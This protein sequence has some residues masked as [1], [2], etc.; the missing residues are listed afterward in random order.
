MRGAT[1]EAEYHQQ[2]MQLKL[3]WLALGLTMVMLAVALPSTTCSAELVWQG[4]VE[5]AAGRGVHGP[6]QQNDSRY[7]YVDDPAVALGE[8]GAI[9]VAWVDQGR[10]DMFFQRI[11]ANG[12]K[13][14]EPVNVSRNPATFSWLP[15]IVVAGMQVSILWQEII[16]SGGSHGG[17]MFFSHS[18]DGG[19]TFS[20]PLNIS[21]SIGGDGKGRINKE[22]WHNGSFDLA[23]GTRPGVLYA[24]WTEYAGTLWFSR[25]SDGGRHFS[26]PQRVTGSE[27]IKPARAPSL[28]VGRDGSVYLAWTTGDD[29]AAD[30][31]VAKS[32]D[33]GTSFDDARIIAPSKTYSDAPK[34]AIDARGILHL[35]YAESVSGPF[36]RYQIRYT[37]S[38]DGARTFETPRAISGPM[39][40]GFVS[41]AFPSLGMDAH[42]DVIVTWEL[43]RNH[44]DRPHGLGFSISGDAGHS[45]SQP[46][47]LPDSSDSGGAANGSQQGLL[48]QKLSVNGSGAVASA[49]SSLKRDERSRV[50]LMRGAI[51]HDAVSGNKK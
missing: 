9:A 41:A 23:A 32:T 8:D 49:N 14:S 10:K 42:G 13:L 36:D 29:D 35:A 50:W 17:D 39:P 1:Q 38:F 43:Y 31:H 34:L 44:R 46:A 11:S 15:R 20:E 2:I 7:D 30:I 19:K 28:A 5:I 22:I 33:D 40:Q 18:Q 45:F 21:H 37:R 51:R 47:V 48:M 27:T 25:S 24:A 4:T 12:S 26:A 6:W 16:F 3:S